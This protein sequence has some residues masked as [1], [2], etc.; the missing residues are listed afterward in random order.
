M[1]DLITLALAKKGGSSG[2]VTPEEMAAAIQSAIG[3]ALAN[4]Y[5]KTETDEE[6]ANYTPTDGVGAEIAVSMDSSYNLTVSLKNAES[7][8]LGSDTVNLPLESMVVGGAYADGV[9]T[10]TLNNGET[11]DIP[12]SDIIDGLVSESRTIAGLPLTSDITTAQMLSALG[13]EGGFQKRSEYIECEIDLDSEEVTITDER[14]TD[15]AEFYDDLVNFAASGRDVYM[16]ARFDLLDA[17]LNA[18]LTAITDN[19]EYDFECLLDGAA[20][21]LA[22]YSSGA[23]WSFCSIE[24]IDDIQEAIEDDDLSSPVSVGGI[25]E[26]AQKKITSDNKLPYSLL[27]GAPANL[28]TGYNNTAYT[29]RPITQTDYNAL[30]TKDANTLYLITG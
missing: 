23:Y 5:T 24:A 2:G 16:H 9:L 17:D 27:D 22:V 21:F 30:G 8:T 19:G 4:Y 14:Y 7:E 15:Y 1:I 13:G 12:I 3:T 29:M 28:V 18:R 6:F 10:L 11:L 20:I 26:Y 25:A